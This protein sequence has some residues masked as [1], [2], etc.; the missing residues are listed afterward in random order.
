[1]IGKTISH[2]RITRQ[3]GVGGMGVLYE[4]LDL[5]L[6]R[7]VALKFL[8]PESTR[9]P[10]AK[11]RFVQEAKAASALDHPNVCNIHEIDET[12]DGQLFIAMACY[13]GETLK[14]RIARG[15][16]PLAEALA[17][18]KRVAE[19][20][21]KAHERNIVHRDIKPANIFLTTDGL[22]K[23]LDFGLAKLSG[24]TMLTTVGTT[25]GTAGYMSPELAR[26]EDADHRTDLWGLGACLFE[27]VTG[28]LPFTG[29]HE[30]AIIYAILNQETEPVTGLRTGVPQELERLIERCLEKDPG[31]RYQTAGDLAS[32]LGRI[33]PGGSSPTVV[34][35]PRPGARQSHWWLGLG[36]AAGVVLLALA[37]VFFPRFL[38]RSGPSADTDR[39]MMV[40]LPFENL[41]APEDEYFAEGLTEEITSRLA[42]MR[43]LGV[44]S[45]TSAVQ[46][47]NTRK[48][49]TQIGAE[50]GVAYVLEGTVRWQKTGSGGNRIRVTPQLIRVDDDVHLWAERYDEVLEDVF[51]VQADIAM[52]VIEQLN[53]TLQK[54]ERDRVQARPT[55]NMAAYEAYRRGL[56]HCR[57]EPYS[58]STRQLQIQMF[59][60]AVK[61]DPTFALAWAWLARSHANLVNLG[62]DRTPARA[63]AARAAA[64]RALALAPDHPEVRLANGYVYYHAFR[65]FDRALE[66]FRAAR[67]GMPNNS[68]SEQSIGWILR[69]Q[70]NFEEALE[71]IDRA[72]ALNPRDPTL[73]R[74]RGN[75]L[76][77]LRRFQEAVKCYDQAIFLAPDEAA[78]YCM[79]FMALWYS[80]ADLADTRAVLEEMPVR[81]ISTTQFFWFLQE[82]WD[83]DFE[84]AFARLDAIPV[85]VVRMQNLYA[86][87]DLLKGFIYNSLEDEEAKTRHLQAA[88]RILEADLRDQPDDPRIH[89]ALGNTLAMLGHPAEA[90][91]AARRAVELCPREVNALHH[92][93][94]VS[95]LAITY[96]LAGDLDSALDQLDYLATIPGGQSAASLRRDPRWEPLRG[97]PHF[98]KLIHTMESLEP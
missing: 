59:E 76:M 10:E 32:D 73:L 17:I 14:D 11:A 61:L 78:G 23:I 66:E 92:P 52:K 47:K 77:P 50:L 49:I 97:L 74:E 33:Q 55:E 67:H 46:Y 44:I 69:R 85:E 88:R 19:G 82:I 30:Q 7:T 79:K 41:G 43:E 65:N 3:L 35:R 70:G 39:I 94:F 5:K 24:R 42:V 29:D 45:R 48:T 13:D 40:V 96:V 20:L 26:G 68:E 28:R 63:A 21:A 86:P 4:A 25:L 81:T 15:P 93:N 75:T 2:Y 62:F 89:A 98:E 83:K 27:M 72:L 58:E 6:D 37:V 56:Y 8:P 12:D 16:L 91:S 90:I 87:K 71:F 18:T 22:V 53:M 51:Q 36:G 80:G 54:S 34:A 9:D 57:R 1:M 38:D 31:A 95:S 60:R 64:D 84:A